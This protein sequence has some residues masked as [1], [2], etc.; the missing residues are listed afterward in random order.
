VREEDLPVLLPI[1]EN[2][3]SEL[4]KKHGNPLA[5]NDSFLNT[6]VNINLK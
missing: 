1:I 3:V 5:T 4:F 2:D 6:K